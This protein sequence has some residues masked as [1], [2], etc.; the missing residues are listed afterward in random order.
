MA[1]KHELLTSS[2]FSEK[3]GIPTSKVSKLIRDGKLKAVKKS[4]K[5]LIESSQLK[6][7]TVI[8]A[9]KKSGPSAKK[10]SSKSAAKKPAIKK[11]ETP[12]DSQ[13]TYSIA[14]FAD[15]TYLTEKGVAEWLKAGL[16]T[17]NQDS[18]GAWRVDAGNLEVPNVKRLVRET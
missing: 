8:K 12:T 14:E 16:L 1:K 9:M 7:K 5:W 2:E 10:K 13:K 15:I 18:G 4:G 17:G 3:S 11:E 6:A